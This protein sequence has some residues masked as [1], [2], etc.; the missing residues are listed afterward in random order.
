[1]K[2]PLKSYFQMARTIGRKENV[3]SSVMTQTN[4]TWVRDLGL[5]NWND[6]SNKSSKLSDCASA[7]GSSRGKREADNMEQTSHTEQKRKVDSIKEQEMPL[8]SGDYVKTS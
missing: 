4:I 6:L 8:V 1:M 3:P 7:P 5:A 2:F